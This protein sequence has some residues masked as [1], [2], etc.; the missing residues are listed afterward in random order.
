MARSVNPNTT[1]PQTVTITIATNATGTSAL[2]VIAGNR[3]I[4]IVP[5]ASATPTATATALKAAIEAVR[6]DV[7]ISQASGVLTV[8][9]PALEVWHGY[10][11]D[12]TQTCVVSGSGYDQNILASATAAAG[13]P[14]DPDDGYRIDAGY[15]TDE[16]GACTVIIR[17][18]LRNT[19]G[20]AATA[21]WRLWWYSPVLGWY[22]DPS[23]G[24]QNLSAGA[25]EAGYYVAAAV[26]AAGYGT[27]AAVELMGKTSGGTNL[28]S[29]ETLLVWMEVR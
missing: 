7:A 17:A 15:V 22:V 13:K 25:A 10:S 4:A 8:T 12:S 11:T 19:S 14:A 24:V 20:G 29:G 23:V 21:A 3:N 1:S 26:A 6:A 18:A 16:D 9:L 2:G 5:G 27:R 28:D